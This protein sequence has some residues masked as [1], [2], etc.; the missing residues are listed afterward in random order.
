MGRKSLGARPLTN[1]EKQARVRK[2]RNEEIQRLRAFVQWV[3][4]HSKEPAVVREAI[5]QGAKLS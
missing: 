5:N 4:E 3:A 2:A 1:A